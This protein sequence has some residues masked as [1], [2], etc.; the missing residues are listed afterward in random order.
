MFWEHVQYKVGQLSLEKH[1]YTIPQNFR[2]ITNS[3]VPIS[4]T[5][6]ARNFSAI[7]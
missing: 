1:A 3:S 7:N 6:R 4:S 5:K 2:L